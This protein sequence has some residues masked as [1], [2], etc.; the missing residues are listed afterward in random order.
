MS[1]EPSF[2]KIL[3][4]GGT[5]FIGQ[6][7]LQELVSAGCHPISIARRLDQVE[8]LSDVLKDEV[9]WIELDLLNREGVKKFIDEERPSVLFHL[10]G[11]RGVYDDRRN[12]AST[13]HELNVDATLHLLE[14]ANRTGTGRIVT[15]GSAEEY[16]R[17]HCDRGDAVR[18]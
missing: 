10:A 18:H 8:T 6:H 13:C 3:V 5:G 9:R 12:A 2:E 11:T 16:G 15:T 7:L 4:T 14:I 1:R 17:S